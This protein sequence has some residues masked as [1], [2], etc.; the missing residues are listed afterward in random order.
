M[1]AI[2]S[3]IP[4]E[5]A[6]DKV[7]GAAHYPGDLAMEGIL[8][9]VTLLARRPHARVTRLDIAD[10]E[11]S[12]G[13]VRIFTSV[14]VP[15]NRFGLIVPDQPVLCG[16]G[17]DAHAAVVRFVGD[18]IALVVAE[19]LAA[20]ER[21][22]DLIR[23]EY[24][25]LPVVTDPRAAMQPGA[26]AL[27]A[28]H[29]DNILHQYH[30]RRGDIEAAFAQADVIVEGEYSVGAQEHAFLQ[31]EAGLAWIDEDGRVTV[32]AAGQWA[33]EELE[34]IAHSL[35]L[36]EDCV[37]VIHPAIG[38]AFGGREDISIQIV[39]G[40]AALTLQRPVKLVWTREESMIGHHK[41]HPMF[42]RC[43][44]GATRDGRIIAA[45]V[46]LVSDA[47]GYA[48]TSTKVLG[49]ATLMALGPY[50]IPNVKVDSYTV[51]TNNVVTGAFR[52]F[53]AP[54]SHFAAESQVNRLAA[55]L[56]MDPVDLRMKNILRDGSILP[57][58]SV[59]PSGVSLETV[60][61]Q[62]AETAG[63]R[64]TAA[65]WQSPLAEP[66]GEPWKR[67]GIGLAAA[68]KNVGFSFGAPENAWAT[69]EL[70]GGGDIERVVVRCA[71]SDVGQGAHQVFKQIA[72][73][74]VGVPL[75]RVEFVGADTGLTP[76]S[77]GSASASRLTFMAGNAI[78]GAA[79]K[80]LEMWRD[81]ED[82][83]VVAVHKYVPPPTTPID[84]DGRSDPNFA[85][86]YVAE[87]VE[88]E[89]DIETGEVRVRRVVCADDVG[90]ALNPHLIQGQIEGAV[91]QAQGWA[92]IENFV[93]QDG[94]VLT[95]HLSTYLI[96]TIL[97]IP[98]RVDSV[99]I[100]VPDPIGPFGAR[101]MAEMPFVPL[102][103]ALT[104]ALYQA[105]GRRFDHLPL[106]PARVLETLYGAGY[107][108]RPVTVEGGL[109]GA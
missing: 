74:A 63:W 18:K 28:N 95:E 12:P 16:P 62:C 101:G 20:A 83:P 47:G 96:P 6:L 24:E 73:D 38:G 92:T 58:H 55:A 91:V 39:L 89:V 3:S 56:G 35:K 60:I 33:H 106:T 41:R 102:A 1:R 88:A 59:I 32:A 9:A 104:E 44:T 93:Q 30:L 108:T 14:D 4:R 5:D 82:R 75:E 68:F 66:A 70:H 87:A 98:E 21:A 78:H 85:Y 25:D 37:R 15:H 94:R 76:G 22:R 46:E 61:T 64:R 54:Q 51:Y 81:E 17:D 72:A 79:Q 7:T 97:D 49:N 19:S 27:H 69:I 57:T 90:R 29:P 40:L 13:V 10:A 71:G 65:G 36:P 52:G 23:V 53:G 26:P 2:G 100:E 34:Q 43:R 45:E 8:H 99:I 105:T 86:G 67:R 107:D 103:P 77:S 109:D 84:H 42:Y 50:D 31:P 80:A 48:S 11:K